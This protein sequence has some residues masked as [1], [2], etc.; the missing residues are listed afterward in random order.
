[1]GGLR[2]FGTSLEDGGRCP[3]SKDLAGLE[4]DWVGLEAGDVVAAVDEGDFAGDA[5]GEGAGEEEGGVADLGLLDVAAEWGAI[6]GGFEHGLEVADAAGGEGFDGTGGDGVDADAAGAEGGGEVADGGLESGF[7]DAHDVVVGEGFGGAVVGEGEDGG[8]LGHEGGGAAGEGDER[9]DADVVGDVEVFAGGEE[10]V[11]VHGGGGGE[12]DGV[13]EGV[14]F[15]EVL[16]DLGEDVVDLVVFGD[17]A[18]E[19]LGGA[20]LAE[21]FEELLGLFAEAFGL[22]AE[23]QGGSGFGEFLRDAVRDGAL[24]G[25]AEDDGDFALHVNHSGGVL[26]G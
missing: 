2:D 3:G 5:G 19:G 6:G 23:D 18:L 21:I 8:A 20:G 9:V 16:F 4:A 22:V 26:P 17:V 11:V 10:E 12:G 13:D 14:D 15:A 25:E 7:S 1:M 24:V